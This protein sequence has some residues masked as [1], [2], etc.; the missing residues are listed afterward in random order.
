MVPPS[1]KPL[2]SMF[3]ICNLYFNRDV[4]LF[5][6]LIWIFLNSIVGFSMNN[7]FLLYRSSH[8]ATVLLGISFQL[9]NNNKA[10]NESRFLL[11]LKLQ[12]NTK[13]MFIVS[14]G[15]MR[16]NWL[17]VFNAVVDSCTL[18]LK[19]YVDHFTVKKTGSLQIWILNHIRNRYPLSSS[20][21]IIY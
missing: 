16:C 5:W 6:I 7:E 12:A 9:L 18:E 8:L 19:W 4:L 10:K 2:M 20:R 21:T 13:I 1:M 11:H 3:K 15:S 17:I 14:L